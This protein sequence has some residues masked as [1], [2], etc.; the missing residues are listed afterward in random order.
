MATSTDLRAAIEEIQEH[1]PQRV[2]KVDLEEA[3]A[4]AKKVWTEK[5][6]ERIGSMP[7]WMI[8]SIIHG[9]LLMLASLLAAAMPDLRPEP[10]QIRIIRPSAPPEKFVEAPPVRPTFDPD[11][12][13]FD[14]I[15]DDAY[16][17]AV[18]REPSERDETRNPELPDERSARGD[19]DEISDMPSPD[20][21]H[22]AVLGF[23]SGMSGKPFGFSQR[24]GRHNLVRRFGG[25]GTQG[26]VDRAIRWLAR[27]QEPDGHWDPSKWDNGK[28]AVGMTG[29]A[30]LTFLGAGHTEKAGKYKDNV[31]RAQNWLIARLK[32]VSSRKGTRCKYG[33]FYTNLYEQ[34]MATLA[35]AEAYAMTEDRR[36]KKAAQAAVDYVVSAQG[37]YEA[38]NYSS[39]RGKA[40]RN[41]TSVSGWN[42][43]ALK[44]AKLAQ[45]T[46]DGNAFQGCMRWVNGATDPGNGRCAYAGT[47]DSVRRG[48]G[49][50]AMC[51]AGMLMRQFM[52]VGPGNPLLIKSA[53]T[54]RR[55]QP[56]SPEAGGAGGR[57]RINYYHVYYASL[58]MFQMGGKYWREWNK[59][60]K[61]AL[62][63]RQRTGGP[64]DGTAADV[65]GSWDPTRGGKVD[66]GGRV[67]STT[68][69]ALTLEVYYRYLPV[70]SK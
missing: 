4:R 19:I 54:L 25:Q 12:K 52:G 63:E 41:D 39:K 16:R 50:L 26:A 66:V 1:L 33:F 64:L 22:I 37:P 5:F 11:R 51:A 49:S 17:P 31:R 58:C 13:I 7:W 53:E 28:G 3:L 43:M 61:P 47:L 8:S 9:L 45:L 62:V 35:L 57:D 18:D 6:G 29:M 48:R 69:A 34:G 65:D 36:L 55:Y 14:R 15:K 68:L 30:L 60:M 27:H 70:Y 46:V 23:G 10:E 67:F 2:E 38:W 44:S 59:S 42:L 32:E 40:G 24:A 20:R 21:G 56:K